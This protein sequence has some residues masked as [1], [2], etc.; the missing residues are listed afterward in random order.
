MVEKKTTNLINFDFNINKQFWNLHDNVTNLVFIPLEH[1]S[2]NWSFESD[3]KVIL[4]LKRFF[5][6]DIHV[7]WTGGLP[8]QTRFILR[9]SP[10]MKWRRILFYYFYW[11]FGLN[12]WKSPLWRQRVPNFDPYYLNLPFRPQ[13]ELII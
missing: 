10:L 4:L 1:A 2:I 11:Q 7:K 6:E 13:S 8:F 12:L 9:G 3:D 5:Y